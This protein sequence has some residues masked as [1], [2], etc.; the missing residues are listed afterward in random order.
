MLFAIARCAIF[1]YTNPK[2]WDENH[3][4]DEAPIFLVYAKK[5][6]GSKYVDRLVNH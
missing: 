1:C 4:G 6:V 5:N 3:I 2:E